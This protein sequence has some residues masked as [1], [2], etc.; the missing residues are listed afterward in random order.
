MTQP[1]VDVTGRRREHQR[2]VRRRRLRL[3]AAVLAVAA[4][5][6]GLV[7]VVFGSPLL[8]AREVEVGGTALLTPESVVQT[9]AVPLGVPLA[10]VA[11]GEVA[12]RVRTLAPVAAVEVAL[13]WPHTVTVTVTERELRL[14]REHAGSF[15]WVDGTG[16]IFHATPERPDG[17]VLAEASSDEPELLA[18]MV[19]VA[20]ALPAPVRERV[21]LLRADSPDSIE[22]VLADGSRIVWGSAGESDLKAQI[23]VA[24]LQVEARVYDVSAPSHPTTRGS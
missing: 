16:T 20:D 11:T 13:R 19:R 4:V 10:R 18:D 24:V 22:V 15:E 12:D 17:A 8:V 6:G 1:L 23:V 5:A 7:W 21:S 9:A 3:L 2:R 14:V